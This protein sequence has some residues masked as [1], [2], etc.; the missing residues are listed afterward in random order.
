[1]SEH[2]GIDANAPDVVPK[3]YDDAVQLLAAAHSAG[4]DPVEIFFVPDPQAK[5]VRLIEV[6]DAFPEGGVER[7]SQNG[8]ELIVPVFPMGP[9]KDFPF[10]SEVAQVTPV[11][12]AK[13]KD[14]TL[15]LNLDW[16]IKQA[17]KVSNGE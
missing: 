17:Q 10:R 6:S 3:T 8:I 13:L 16:D 14:K 11:E 15:K 5:I 2:A 7:P 4:G 1:M 12:W 9:A